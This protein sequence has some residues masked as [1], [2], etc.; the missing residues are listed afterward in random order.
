MAPTS[1]EWKDEL[2][3]Q[4]ENIG[5]SV[6]M[7]SKGGEIM[8]GIMKDSK[9]LCKKSNIFLI[10]HGKTITTRHLNGSKVHLNKT[11]TKYNQTPLLN[12]SYYI[13]TINFT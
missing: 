11:G 7:T 1:E 5:R 9:E 10:Q 2:A 6:G 13:M 8:K 4:R 12:F 3:Y